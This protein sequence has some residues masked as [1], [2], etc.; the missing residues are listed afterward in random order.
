MFQILKNAN[1]FK[2]FGHSDLQ[3]L[4]RKYCKLLKAN[5]ARSLQGLP[6]GFPDFLQGFP[7]I[8]QGFLEILQGLARFRQEL[9]YPCQE[10]LNNCR[11]FVIYVGN[12]CTPIVQ[13]CGHSGPLRK[14]VDAPPKMDSDGGG[15]LFLGII[16]ASSDS[17]R[18]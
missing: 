9:W 18:L 15:S 8:L 14:L 2:D 13:I 6:Q 4:T 16:S 12:P 7:N 1:M 3:E 5:P 11:I 10:S 17:E